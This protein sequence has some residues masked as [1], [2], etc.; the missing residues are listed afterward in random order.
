MNR[1]KAANDSI[2]KYTLIYSL[3]K[4]DAIMFRITKITGIEMLYK[5]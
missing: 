5:K 1:N 3:I 4:S 2:A